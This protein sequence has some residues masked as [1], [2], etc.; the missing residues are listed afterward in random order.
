MTKKSLFGRIAQLVKANANSA[1]DASEDPQKMLDQMVRDYT[2]NIA[3]A[4]ASVAQTIGN[5][6]LLQDDHRED[7]RTAEDWGRKA[8]AASAKADEF[9][10]AGG[11][12]DA[13][14]FD[15]LARVAIGRQLQ[16][17]K[18]ARDAEPTIAAQ[19]EIVAKL[20]AGLEAMKAKR[21]QLVAKRDELVARSR[22]AAAQN[23]MMDA[24]KSV[25]LL[26]PAGE[27]GRFEEKIRREEARVRGAA[28][29]AAS[30]LDGQFEELENL[31]EASEVEARLAALKAA[32][33]QRELGS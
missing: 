27:V 22:T 12:A 32:N 10:A 19:E 25:D 14:K 21:A 17:E 29:L 6:R 5:L 9:R 23:Q 15:E 4:E 24:V 31:G 8:L 18:E 28:E 16:H 30:S 20:K 26:D 3:E 11:L 7:L 13:A 33:R 2:N 1:I